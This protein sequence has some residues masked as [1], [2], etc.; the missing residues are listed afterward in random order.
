MG[1][2]KKTPRIEFQKNVMR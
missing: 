2:E 1:G